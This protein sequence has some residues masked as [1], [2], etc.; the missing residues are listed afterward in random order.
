M[1]R[2]TAELGPGQH[3]S[4]PS[5][6]SST[7][8]DPV[9]WDMGAG[10]E[11]GVSTRR[12]FSLTLPHLPPGGGGREVT[13]Y[14][15][16]TPRSWTQGARSGSMGGD[17]PV[18]GGGTFQKTPSLHQALIP[19]LSKSLTFLETKER[20]A[21]ATAYR[22]TRQTCLCP[23]EAGESQ[24]LGG[25][26]SPGHLL[27]RLA[28]AG[29][30]APS[31]QACGTLHRQAPRGHGVA[32]GEARGAPRSSG[33]ETGSRC[34]AHPFFHPSD[35]RPLT[36]ALFQGPQMIRST[37]NAHRGSSGGPTDTGGSSDL[38]QRRWEGPVVR[39]LV[40]PRP[41]SLLC[42]AFSRVASSGPLSLQ[43]WV[44]GS[45]VCP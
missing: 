44:I 23:Q 28:G 29:G 1:T 17:V 40:A 36:P 33:W 25:S 22:G 3:G 27:T 9:Q 19:L 10:T 5:P 2:S 20:Q 6:V 32:T 16:G 24:A 38:G 4:E 11:F 21:A 14:E 42:W 43:L 41:W 34:F 8:F 45:L 35:S 13:P 12:S 26:G 18:G 39:L 30:P 7:P 37:C 15:P 31:Q